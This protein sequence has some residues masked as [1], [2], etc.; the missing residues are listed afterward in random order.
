[1]GSSSCCNCNSQVYVKTNFFSRT[2]EMSNTQIK[3]KLQQRNSKF[4]ITCSVDCTQ[5]EVSTNTWDFLSLP[6]KCLWIYKV[7][8]HC[9]SLRSIYK[10]PFR[11]MWFTYEVHDWLEKT[12]PLVEWPPL[13][14]SVVVCALWGWTLDQLAKQKAFHQ[15]K[16]AEEVTRS[17]MEQ[18]ET[19]WRDFPVPKPR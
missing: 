15:W 6:L 11:C 19:T 9:A 17:R 14:Q 16:L 10:V 3:E 5:L 18:N 2:L 13:K 1:M 4:T 8:T 12:F 7:R